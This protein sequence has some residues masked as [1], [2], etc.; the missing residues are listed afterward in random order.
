MD[1]IWFIQIDGK[2]EG[3]YSFKDLRCDTRV[4]PDTLVW[5]EGFS[6]WKRIRNVP[7][8]KKLFEEQ[9]DENTSDES[10]VLHAKKGLGED[11]VIDMGQE[12]P[13]LFWL[14]IL[15]LILTYIIM[16]FFWL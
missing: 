10:D 9:E 5:K 6:G 15:I 16:Q 13:Y 4:T 11:L 2:R 7:E 14:L 12:P 3:P 8:L 1:K